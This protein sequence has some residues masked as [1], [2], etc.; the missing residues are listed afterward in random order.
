MLVSDLPTPSFLIDLDMLNNAGTSKNSRTNELMFHPLHLPTH[1]MTLFP[2][3]NDSKMEPM[4]GDVKP[5]NVNE[6]RGQQSALGYVHTSISKARDDF[7]SIN[8]NLQNGSSPILAEIDVP[9]SFVEN[10]KLVMGINNHHVGSYYWARSTGMGAAMEAPGIKV[11]SNAI[12]EDSIDPLSLLRWDKTGYLDSNSNDGK[13]SE[14][15]NFV[16]KGDLVQILPENLENCLM[17]VI[18]RENNSKHPIDIFGFSAKCRPLGSEPIVC[19]RYSYNV[20]K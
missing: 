8:E 2:I 9:F 4:H 19:C 6:F 3:S 17:K 11:C 18:E 16:R 12:L 15:V 20:N 5:Y 1:R 10:A 13:R 14:W 7:Q